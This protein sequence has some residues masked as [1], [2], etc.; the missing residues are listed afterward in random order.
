MSSRKNLI[1]LEQLA[2]FCF[3]FFHKF[4]LH[5]KKKS[6]KCTQHCTFLNECKIYLFSRNSTCAK[7]YIIS[8]N[9]QSEQKIALI[10][11]FLFCGNP[12]ENEPFDTGM[13]APFV[14]SKKRKQNKQRTKSTASSRS[15]SSQR[16]LPMS[17]SQQSQPRSPHRS[18][19]GSPGNSPHSET[20]PLVE[21]KVS[22]PSL[23]G[24]GK[25]N[26]SSQESNH[27]D[28]EITDRTPLHV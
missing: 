23:N 11:Y 6:C 10:L 19:R 3:Q 7:T 22:S 18:P 16:S 25:V 2:C 20:V 27:T 28:L 21:V 8:F 13:R 12:E 5:R 4:F 24:R 14:S 9:V 1:S 15:R 17:A 26:P